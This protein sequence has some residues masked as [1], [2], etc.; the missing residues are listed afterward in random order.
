MSFEL[1]L[2]LV[3]DDIETVNGRVEIRYSEECSRHDVEIRALSS[4]AAFSGKALSHFMLLAM[5]I[6]TN[7]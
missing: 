6:R 3:R 1:T 7:F 5:T 2:S 4:K